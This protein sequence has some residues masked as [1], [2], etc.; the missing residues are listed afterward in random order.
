MSFTPVSGQSAVPP[1]GVY[2]I[3][4][5]SGTEPRRFTMV[6]ETVTWPT[7]ESDRAGTF[8]A[9]PHV[10]T[11]DRTGNTISGYSDWSVGS[12]DTSLGQTPL[13]SPTV[14]NFF[15]PGYKFPG[16]LANNGLVTPEFQISSDTN[17][18]RQANFL[19][20]GIYHTTGTGVTSGYTNGFSSFAGGAHD[21][22]MDFS[23]WMGLRPN[24]T[25][26]WTDTPNLRALIQEM[27]KILMAGQMSQ[28]M[29]DQIYNFVSVNTGT[30]YIS[31]P[32]SP[33]DADRRNRLRAIIYFIAVSPEHAIQR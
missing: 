6:P 33:A 27:S 22:M 2:L 23:P 29:E 25:G 3:Q 28:E 10:P 16:L 18:I 4:S 26:N 1:D 5:I 7:F 32:A 24:A 30:G 15:E 31:Y 21:I 8:N 17:V 13:G 11:L 19:F 20:G 14:F 12:T 9:A